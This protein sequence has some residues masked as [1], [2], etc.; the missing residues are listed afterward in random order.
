VPTRNPSSTDWS[1]LG[2][3]IKAP[4]R[5]LQVR[6]RIQCYLRRYKELR[7]KWH[8]SWELT[9]WVAMYICICLISFSWKM[10]ALMLQK[11]TC[12]SLA[13][14]RQVDLWGYCFNFCSEFLLNPI[15]AKQKGKGKESQYKRSKA[16]IYSETSKWC[17]HFCSAVLQVETVLI[18]DQVHCQTKVPVSTRTTNLERCIHWGVTTKL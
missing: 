5:A 6:Q 14:H 12:W 17:M 1:K 15:P 16:Y 11:L 10:N 3:I 4:K 8:L 18:S 9:W 7:N 13:I 2:N